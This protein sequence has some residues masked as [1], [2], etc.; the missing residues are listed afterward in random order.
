MG[1]VFPGYFLR[2]SAAGLLLAAV[3]GC[4]GSGSSDPLD[5]QGVWR[6][7]VAYDAKQCSP[8]SPPFSPDSVTGQEYRIRITNAP[9][10][11]DRCPGSATDQYGQRYV[12]DVEAPCPL[13]SDTQLLFTPE[14]EVAVLSPTRPT[15]ILFRNIHDRSAD[16]E[17]IYYVDSPNIVTC[18]LVFRGTF[19]RQ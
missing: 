18:A 17:L 7:T 19:S 15:G 5:V 3:F 10:G 11:T 4:G 13:E 16:V 8:S 2:Y 14:E 1:D 9:G 12:V 6:G